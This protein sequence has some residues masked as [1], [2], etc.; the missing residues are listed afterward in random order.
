MVLSR[1]EDPDPVGIVDFWPA[2][3]GSG[4]FSLDPD[5]DPDPTNKFKHKMMGYKG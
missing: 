3:S 4:I 1:D 2:G 5:P